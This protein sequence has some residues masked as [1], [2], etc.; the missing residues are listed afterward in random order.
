MHILLLKQCRSNISNHFAMRGTKHLLTFLTDL[1]IVPGTRHCLLSCGNKMRQS[2][3][4]NK[5]HWICTRQVNGN[6]SNNGKFS[7]RRGTFLD[8]SK[9][10]IQTFLRV[11]WNFVNLKEVRCKQFAGIT[12][13][14]VQGLSFYLQSLDMGAGTYTH[15]RWIR[16][17]SG[18][19]RIVPSLFS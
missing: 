8:H 10:S 19:G 13:K 1:G 5:F 15:I 14:T 2:K 12:T 9:I 18:N 11:L 4:G 17:D 3:Q 16:E 6:K 7:V